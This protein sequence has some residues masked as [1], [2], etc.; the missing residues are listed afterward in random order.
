MNN[1]SHYPQ[2]VVVTGAS[3]GIGRALSIAFSRR[4]WRVALLA[5]NEDALYKTLDKLADNAV[6]H[7]VQPCDISIWTD[8]QQAKE[9]IIEEFGYLN[10][11]VNNAFGYGEAPLDEMDPG[12]IHDCFETG[13]TGNVFI[14]KAL[15]D[16]L[17]VAYSQIGRK[18]NIIN[19]VADWGF[20]MHNIFTGPSVYSAAKYALHGFGVALHREIAPKGINVTNVYPGIVAS[21]FDLDDDL[22]LIQKE[23]GNTAIPL[24]DVVNTVLSIPNQTS[25]TVRHI[26]LSPDNPT[27]DGL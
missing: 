27:Y 22:Q 14:T 11:L 23:M 2:T 6:G 17:A 20:P 15:L 1:Q 9:R 24:V 19:I 8:C 4:G 18:S 26:V 12:D 13:I 7:L 16:P 21:S 10:C 5:R 3:K 25:S